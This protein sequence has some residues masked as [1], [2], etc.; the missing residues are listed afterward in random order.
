MLISDAVHCALGGGSRSGKTFLL[1]RQVIMRA[2]REPFSRHAIFRYRFNA[3]WASVVLD[4]MPKVVRLCFPGLP[5]V[6]DMLN[7]KMGYMTLPN[8]AEI[9]FGGLDDKDLV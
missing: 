9:W 3:L 6:D 2:L 4:T 8:G 1:C 7:K 5:T